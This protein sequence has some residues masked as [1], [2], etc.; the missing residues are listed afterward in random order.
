MKNKPY[1]LYLAIIS[2]ALYIY[3]LH[4]G[5]R[6]SLDAPTWLLWAE[7][8]TAMIFTEELL[9]R[10]KSQKDY[11]KTPLFWVDLVS[12]LPFFV[13]FIVPMNWLE[14]VRALRVLRI[15]KA[16]R[17]CRSLQLV[18]LGFY[19]VWRQ[20]KALLYT[21]MMFMMLNA[22]LIFQIEKDV[23]P[24]FSNL[25]DCMWY[26]FVSTSTIGYGDI[27]PSTE[28]GKAVSVITLSLCLAIFAGLIGII[29]G[30]LSKVMDEEID[31]NINPL[32]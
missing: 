13:G 9:W 20:L 30:S 22:V 21:A 32:K 6:H 28:L 16:F 18:A 25:L 11:I 26:S 3:E 2:V 31:P 29:G 7:R 14:G 24:Q 5:C 12:V 8:A 1:L 17:Y 4:L 15:F 19:R 23:N 27:S 10:I